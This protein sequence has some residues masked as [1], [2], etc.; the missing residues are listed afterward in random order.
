MC[1]RPSARA[2][3][4]SPPRESPAGGAALS[5][6]LRP[7]SA[8][9]AQPGW[10]PGQCGSRDWLVTMG[11]EASVWARPWGFGGRGW[12]TRVCPGCCV[13]AVPPVPCRP[14][15]PRKGGCQGWGLPHPQTPGQ[16]LGS[17]KTA[18]A[19]REHGCAG[20]AMSR[21]SGMRLRQSRP[22]AGA[23]HDASLCTPAIRFTYG[24]SD[25]RRAW[26]CRRAWKASPLCMGAFLAIP[27]W[28]GENH[29]V[30][31][32]GARAS[33]GSA[34]DGTRGGLPKA[35]AGRI[36]LGPGRQAKTWA[37]DFL[38]EFPALPLRWPSPGVSVAGIWPL[39]AGAERK[40]RDRVLG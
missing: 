11:G 23:W 32:P 35:L 3:C 39:S 27:S 40:C 1:H 22:R 19:W 36:P 29:S 12:S 7:R 24:R 21:G 4:S 14:C 13:P 28:A 26:R 2:A 16:P 33:R 5:P 34:M 8:S 25:T 37:S 6:T 20:L 17:R 9:K 15:S 10:E 31:G 38:T 30:P 18:L